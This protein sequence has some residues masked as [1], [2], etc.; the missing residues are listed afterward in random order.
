MSLQLSSMTTVCVLIDQASQLRQT[1]DI[2]GRIKI[3]NVVNHM[4]EL[5]RFGN[6]IYK[7]NYHSTCQAC[8]RR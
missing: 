7:K 6:S 2:D 8:N 4:K 3:S 5:E 1:V